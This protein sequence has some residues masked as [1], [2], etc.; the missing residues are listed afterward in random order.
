MGILRDC[1]SLLKPPCEQ[2]N[3]PNGFRQR[4]GRHPHARAHPAD[5]SNVGVFSKFFPVLVG[6]KGPRI[7]LTIVGRMR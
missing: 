5:T 3:L 7:L 1:Q 2:L 6:K 4:V